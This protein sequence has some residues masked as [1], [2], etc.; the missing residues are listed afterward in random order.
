MSGAPRLTFVQKQEIVRLRDSGRT[1]KEIARLV[2]CTVEQIRHYWSLLTDKTYAE[3]RRRIAQKA[4]QRKRKAAKID[5]GEGQILAPRDSRQLALA[6]KALQEEIQLAKAEAKTAPRFK[7]T[8]E[9]WGR[10]E[11]PDSGWRW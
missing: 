5:R 2:D 7:L 6:K 8:P 3:R 1:F 4:Q 11:R 10:F 9:E